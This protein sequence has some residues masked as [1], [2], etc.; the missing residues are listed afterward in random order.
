M[1]ILLM[2]GVLTLL[3]VV[4]VCHSGW[5]P[6]GGSASPPNEELFKYIATRLTAVWT[7]RFLPGS[8]IPTPTFDIAS[9][10]FHAFQAP[11][12]LNDNALPLAN[13]DDW[14]LAVFNQHAGV[15]WRGDIVILRMSRTNT[16]RFVNMRAGDA[17][18]SKLLVQMMPSSKSVY[19]ITMNP[20]ARR[21]ARMV[22]KRGPDRSPSVEQT[23]AKSPTTEDTRATSMLTPPPSSPP[24]DQDDRE[25]TLSGEADRRDTSNVSTVP[26]PDKEEP[27]VVADVTSVPAA[28]VNPSRGNGQQTLK[29]A[30]GSKAVNSAK[31]IV[32]LVSRINEPWG[33]ELK[34]RLRSIIESS[35]VPNMR[36]NIYDPPKA[37][38]SWKRSE[39]DNNAQRLVIGDKVPR[40][41][42]VGE[43]AKDGAWL[44]GK[45][46]SALK[47][48]SM[49]I[50]PIRAGEYNKWLSFLDE[51][52]GLRMEE[53]R[54]AG[55]IVASRRMT[56]RSK[57]ETDAIPLNFDQ[58]Y[59]AQTA[60]RPYE[61][62]DT[63]PKANVGV[64]DVVLIEV[65]V[66]RWQCNRS[67][68]TVYNAG[69]EVYR[70]GF[71]LVAVSQLFSGP[72]ETPPAFVS[73][74]SNDSFE[75]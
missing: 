34:V 32:Q 20:S 6:S 73:N 28:G 13:A 64:N 58:C 24:N 5:S 48:V 35:D 67:G 45:G 22:T 55:K 25:S 12:Y 21:S 2:L 17:A 59:D 50:Y 49:A 1:T 33:P 15:T 54:K 14:N 61:R 72:D 71:E 52:G 9:W 3:C 75:F 46:N 42:I 65:H 53:L 36:Y 40:F 29:S 44:I 63:Y 8:E 51:L 62:M 37:P 18:R 43:V 66:T 60:L 57:G 39:S 31:E 23:Q 69:W 47:Q 41:W 27:L 16:H 26:S 10:M 74:T 4:L 56:H 19:P 7:F 30:A 70:V 68:K 38:F 11:L